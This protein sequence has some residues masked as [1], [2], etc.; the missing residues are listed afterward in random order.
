MSKRKYSKKF[1]L[2][3]LKE[4]EEGASFYSL[5]KKY[6]S[7][8]MKKILRVCRKKKIQSCVKHRYN[9]CK[10]PASDPAYIVENI[11]NREIKPDKPNEKWL[12]FVSEFK[13]GTGEDEKKGKIYLS[14]I[15][16]LCGNRPAAFECTDYNNNPLVFKNFDKALL[17]NP[18]AMPIFYSDR[19]YQ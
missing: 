11:L 6:Q 14:V 17:A 16:Y 10:K 4:H 12:T 1:K 13:Y 2:K 19:G 15:L 5:E 8:S 7:M 3:V 9:C 18:G